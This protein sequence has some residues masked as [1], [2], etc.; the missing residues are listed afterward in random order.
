MGTPI[1]NLADILRDE[2]GM[3][4][5]IAELL[6]E[7][8]RTIPE[9]ARDFPAPEREVTLWVMAMRRYGLL[10]DLPKSKAD[11]YYRY[12]TVPDRSEGDHR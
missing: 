11:D 10:E 5:R 1:R 2:A 8:P 7:S 12:R 9:I 6:R 4:E 3:H